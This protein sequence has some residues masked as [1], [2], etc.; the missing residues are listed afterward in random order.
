MRWNVVRRGAQGRPL[1]FLIVDDSEDDKLV[2]LFATEDEAPSSRFGGTW[3][4][5]LEG[6]PFVA[7]HVI[8]R[9]AGRSGFARWWTISNPERSLLE[10]VLVVPHVVAIMPAEIVGDATSYED[11]LP[12]LASALIVEVADRPPLVELLLGRH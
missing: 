3:T 2:G 6:D 8:E 7:F 9:G 11:L 1:I 10:T 12:R 5:P 4:A